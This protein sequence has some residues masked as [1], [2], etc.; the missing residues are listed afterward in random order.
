MVSFAAT[1]LSLAEIDL[2]IFLEFFDNIMYRRWWNIEGFAFNIHSERI[3]QCVDA[4]LADIFTF[5]K[6]CLYKL[7]HLCPWSCYRPVAN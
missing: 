1:V 6:L 3:L 2:S 7:L 5:E 4:V